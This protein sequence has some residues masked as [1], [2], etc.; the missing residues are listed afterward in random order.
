MALTVADVLK[1]KK[2]EI[3]SIQPDK[4]ILDAIHVLSER[5]IGSLVVTDGGKMI[6]LITERDVLVECGRKPDQLK[7]TKVREVMTKSVYT[8]VE[9]DS[10]KAVQR[11]MTERRIRHLPITRENR[12][13][14]M[15]SIGDVVKLLLK[16]STEEADEL[17]TELAGHYIV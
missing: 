14:G 3:V 2:S 11:T 13:I 6:G 10:L 8:G 15:V 1:D 17:R 12:V 5:R 16:E 9:D 4:S 7:T